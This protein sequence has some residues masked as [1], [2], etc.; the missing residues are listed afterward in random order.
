M[1]IGAVKVK[2][3]GRLAAYEGNGKNGGG[4]LKANATHPGCY[5]KPGSLKRR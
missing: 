4:H 2:L 3:A 1:K 5:T